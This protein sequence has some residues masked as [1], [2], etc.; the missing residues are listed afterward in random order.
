MKS[1]LFG[2][3]CTV[4]LFASCINSSMYQQSKSISD[5]GWNKDSIIRFVVPVADTVSMFD[6]YI[7]I[8]NKNDYPNQNLYL[9][10][11]T[12]S[13]R[14]IFITD[15]INFLVAD[16]YGTWTGKSISR[17]WE[18]N[19]L[20]RKNIRFAN[21]GQYIFDIQQGMRYDILSGISDVGIEIK[22]TDVEKK[23][24]GQK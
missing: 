3:L 24:N 21:S 16:D 11:K 5:E 19:F 15:T 10:V 4:M 17:I 6:I 9:F 23:Y 13:P 12:I 22:S 8:R 7:S 2:V 14:G 18:N 1:K 20:F